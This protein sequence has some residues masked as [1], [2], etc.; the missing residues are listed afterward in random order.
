[1]YPEDRVLIGVINRQRDFISL[2]DQHWYRIPFS[3]GVDVHVD[4][5]AFFMSRSF[6]ALNGGIYYYAE[7]RG[8]EL[9]HRCDLIPDEPNHKRA[10]EV[11]YK[12]QVG[13]LIEKTPPIL[14][15][16]RRVVSF[17]V[18]TWDRFEVASQIDDLYSLDE[19]FVERLERAPH[20]QRP[21]K[22]CLSSTE[23]W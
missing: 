2:R 13:M 18:T 23:L 21:V 8:V 11:Y 10:Y 14:N 19:A 7:R 22:L 1:M 12:V 4:V 15:T 17:I 20:T 16:T 9:A 6:K 3:A 5:V